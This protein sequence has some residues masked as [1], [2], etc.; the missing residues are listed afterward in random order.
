[1]VWEGL[2][3]SRTQVTLGRVCR[4]G[5]GGRWEVR[6]ELKA[7]PREEGMKAGGSQEDQ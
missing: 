6:G 2:K 7:V 5:H 1:M 3:E 4:L